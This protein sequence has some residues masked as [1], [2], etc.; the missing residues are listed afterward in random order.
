MY[1]HRKRETGE[2]IKQGLIQLCIDRIPTGGVGTVIRADNAPGFR[3]LC[4]DD[5]LHQHG[6]SIEL[7]RTKNVNK[8]PVAE[9]CSITPTT[10]AVA[11]AS[12]NTGIQ[13]RGLSARE[14]WSH[15]DQI[16]NAQLPVLD[17]EIIAKQ[18]RAREKKHFYS[19]VSK[20]P[21]ARKCP[22]PSVAPGVL[23][24]LV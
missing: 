12:L 7:G 23:V 13:S 18:H 24:Y 11:M 20:C 5:T 14:L 6:I 8:N 16:S 10:L 19:E 22:E 2:C 9:M 1:A 21:S 17:Q 15:R 4:D 3:S